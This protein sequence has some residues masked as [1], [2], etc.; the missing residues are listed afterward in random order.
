MSPNAG[1]T[2]SRAPAE[3]SEARRT[4]SRTTD[5]TPSAP[6]SIWA[7]APRRSRS[8][9]TAM[10]TA[11]AW[12]DCSD[13]PSDC[14]APRASA[15]ARDKIGCLATADESDA[16]SFA[17]SWAAES[18][19]ICWRRLRMSADT[20]SRGS[21]DAGRCLTTLALANSQLGSRPT[22]CCDDPPRHL[23]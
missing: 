13:T 15:R 9:N 17:A 11:R 23:V 1:P 12:G 10:S 20:A 22:P 5:N 19:F 14:R 3:S 7:G 18:A 21:D 4:E 16:Q 8:E 2:L 6:R